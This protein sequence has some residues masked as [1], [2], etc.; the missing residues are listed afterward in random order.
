MG[1]L[2]CNRAKCEA[3]MCD[4]YSHDYGYICSDCYW[5]LTESCTLD[6]QRFMDTPKPKTAP[7]VTVD[8]DE[9]FPMSK[10]WG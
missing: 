8:Y 7:G 3:I 1:V 10:G 9:I 6:V 4:R 2:P 5:D